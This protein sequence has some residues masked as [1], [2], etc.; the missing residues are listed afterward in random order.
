MLFPATRLTSLVSTAPLFP[1]LTQ[2]PLPDLTT[3]QACEGLSSPGYRCPE[4]CLALGNS[5]PARVCWLNKREW[6]REIDEHFRVQP[7]IMG[8]AI[9]SLNGNPKQDLYFSFKSCATTL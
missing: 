3:H 6:D 5:H 7:R 2:L 4:E 1:P 9:N 8:V